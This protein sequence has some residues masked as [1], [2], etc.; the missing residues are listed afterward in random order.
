MKFACIAHVCKQRIMTKIKT[1]IVYLLG[2]IS[3]Y[4][5][6]IDLILLKNKVHTY[7]MKLYHY[8]HQHMMEVH[9]DMQKI[10]KSQNAKTMKMKLNYR[11]TMKT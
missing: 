7:M 6:D 8:I 5:G 2:K 10:T 4:E 1:T 11:V 3:S 9:K